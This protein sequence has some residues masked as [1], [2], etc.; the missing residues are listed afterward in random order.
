MARPGMVPAIVGAALLAVAVW[1][2]TGAAETRSYVLF[3][4]GGVTLAVGVL[5]MLDRHPAAR[6]ASRALAGVLG[7]AAALAAGTGLAAWGW[8]VF[9]GSTNGD[10]DCTVSFLPCPVLGG[11]AMVAGAVVAAVGAWYAVTGLIDLA[12]RR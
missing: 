3:A 2:E 1:L 10:F 6:T 12:R 9:D 8:W 7:M 11:V 4:A 5:R